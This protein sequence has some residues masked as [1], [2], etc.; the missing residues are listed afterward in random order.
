[1]TDMHPNIDEKKCLQI[2]EYSVKSGGCGV[3]TLQAMLQNIG[4]FLLTP[5]FQIPRIT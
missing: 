5:F 4:H 2:T 3:R 1:M